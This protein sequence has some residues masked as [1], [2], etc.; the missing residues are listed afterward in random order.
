MISSARKIQIQ[1]NLNEN[2]YSFL[3][4]VIPL[5]LIKSVQGYA[6][7]LLNCDNE[8]NAIIWSMSELEQSSKDDFYNFCK[9]MGQILPVMEVALLPD[10]V[11]IAKITLKTNNI[12]LS[13]CAVFFNKIDAKRLQYDWHTEKSYFPNA[14]E[15]LTLWYPWLHDVN[16]E[17]GTMILAEGSHKKSYRA[18]RIDVRDGLTQMK[19]DEDYLREFDFIP[20]NLGLGDCVLFR[21]NLAHRTGPN[22]SGIPRTTLITR[23]TDFGGKFEG[24]WL[25]GRF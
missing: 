25:A 13:D 4:G 7:E 3:K 6:A 15:V 21:L 5:E 17:N 22:N 1:S 12:Y 23:F 19:I 10:L 16:V 11:E 2:G 9:Q 24:G 8:S 20:C 18:R 14:D